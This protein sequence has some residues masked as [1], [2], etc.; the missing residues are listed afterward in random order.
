MST[1]AS[2]PGSGASAVF[3]A[4]WPPVLMMLVL[5]V[6]F[7]LGDNILKSQQYDQDLY[8]IQVIRQ[9]EA[10]LPIP[11]FSNYGAATGPGYHLAYALVGS[12]IG[13]DIQTLRW[14]SPI[15]AIGLIVV[16]AGFCST[17]CKPIAAALLTAPLAVSYY[18]VG[19]AVYLQTDNLAWLLVALALGPLI[20]RPTC[21][22]SLLRSGLFLLLAVLVRQNFIWLAGPIVL[23]GLLTTPLAR[24]IPFLGFTAEEARRSSRTLW[25]WGLVAVVPGC[26]LLG[27]FRWTWGG[28]VPPNFQYFH[29]FHVVWVAAGFALALVGLYAPFFLLAVPRCGELI[30]RHSNWLILAGVVGGA[31][32]L[33]PCS[34][35]DPEFGRSGGLMWR[36]VRL[37]PDIADRSLVLGF[38]SAFGAAS[39]TLIGFAICQAGQQR[40]GLVLLCGWLAST[41]T[42]FLN[43]QSYQRYYDFPSLLVLVWGIALC[44]RGHPAA[45]RRVAYGPP[46]LAVI[47][48][49]LF[50]ISIL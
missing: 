10:Q 23:C 16:V 19:S 47:L 24:R 8:H 18:L 13:S 33:V 34:S 28:L 26:L 14:F 11:D 44:L 38:F 30:R 7:L 15:I 31:C 39:L 40:G 29:S 9:F 27:V 25:L 20:F 17:C 41:S 3:G 49:V 43:S 42:M 46:L 37:G 45:D 22:W 1:A 32:A 50:A 2:E 5:A 48:A 35:F 4:S 36:L 12:L 6:G 21:G